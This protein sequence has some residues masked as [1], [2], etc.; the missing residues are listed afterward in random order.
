MPTAARRPRPGHPRA[1]AP[2]RAAV[3]PL[4]LLALVREAEVDGDWFMVGYATVGML[5]TLGPRDVEPEEWA[6]RVGTLLELIED[7]DDP[8]S[9]RWLRRELGQVLMLVPEAGRGELLAGVVDAYRE[10]AIGDGRR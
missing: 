8:T 3:L 4:W 6:A 5:D 7:G 9:L 2:D 1:P 10:G